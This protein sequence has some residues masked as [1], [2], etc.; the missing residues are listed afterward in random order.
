MDYL[1]D[2]EIMDAKPVAIV[3][4]AYLFGKTV[5]CYDVDVA[6]FLYE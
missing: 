1:A 6:R 3:P 2:I 4:L 5:T